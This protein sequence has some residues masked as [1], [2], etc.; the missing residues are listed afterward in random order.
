MRRGSTYRSSHHGTK[1]VGNKSNHGRPRISPRLR[2]T[3]A[4]ATFLPPF[5]LL[6]STHSPSSLLL[7]RCC[8]ELDF[9]SPGYRALSSVPPL[10]R[11]LPHRIAHHGESC[12]PNVSKGH[13][14]ESTVYRRTHCRGQACLYLREPRPEG[15]LLDQVSPWRRQVD[16]THGGQGCHRRDQCVWSPSQESIPLVSNH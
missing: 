15:G 6:H 1:S 9:P 5:Q 7:K 12:T 3:S 13:S 4:P 16:P 10:S 14:S 11:L 2:S 8:C